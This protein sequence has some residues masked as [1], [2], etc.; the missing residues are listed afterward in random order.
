MICR[1]LCFILLA[2]G[3]K[4]QA[5]LIPYY[6]M[7]SLVLLSDAIVLCEE[8]DVQSKV[9]EHEKWTE[10]KTLVTCRVVRSFKGDLKAGSEFPL[11]YDSL[12]RRYRG[13][14]ADY[15][16]EVTIT[17]EV[18][19]VPTKRLPAGRALL[20]L[21]KNTDSPSYSVVTAKLIQGDEVLQFG[22]FYMNPGPLVLAPQQPENLKL[23]AG[24]KYREAELIEDLLV[25]L[26]KAASL[27]EPVRLPAS[28]ALGKR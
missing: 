27:K 20:F 21:K 3:F 25:A 5:A 2:S 13:I 16:S 15:T 22:Q 6:R 7:D 18:K 23:S 8:E 11:E 19:H 9:V 26:D 4:T 24:Q 12:F 28:T 17:G 14:Q 10:T 1:I